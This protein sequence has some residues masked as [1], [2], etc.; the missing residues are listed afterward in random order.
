[1][2]FIDRKFYEMTFHRKYFMDILLTG[3][4]IVWYKRIDSLPQTLNFKFLYLC[5][6][7]LS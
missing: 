7:V 4:F 1:M 3:H 5:N 6:P 2:T